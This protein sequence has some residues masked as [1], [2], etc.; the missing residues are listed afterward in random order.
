VKARIESPE[1]G[2]VKDLPAIQ[3]RCGVI[4]VTGS[5]LA[6]TSTLRNSGDCHPGTAVTWARP[7]IIR[8]DFLINFEEQF[9]DEM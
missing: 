3:T 8:R 7:V 4:Y 5:V 9:Y 2:N 6:S 1:M